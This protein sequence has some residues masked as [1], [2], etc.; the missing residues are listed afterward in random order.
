MYK[1]YCRV[2]QTILRVASYVLPWRKAS[3][4][5]GNNVFSKLSKI[6][7]EDNI[8]KVL[9]VSDRVIVDLN[10]LDEML[11]CFKK[12]KIKY[13]IYDGTV[14]NPTVKNVEEAK[15]MYINCSAQAIIA[16]G[17]GSPIDCAKAAASLIAKPNKSIKQLKGILKIRKKIPP[18]YVVPTTAG[19]GSE[20]TLA[21]VISDD[22]THQKYVMYDV[23]LIPKYAVLNPKVTINLPRSVTA[24][25]GMDV[26]THAVEAYIGRA[27]TKETLQLSKEAIVL[28]YDNLEIAC[29]DGNNLV[30]RENMLKASYLAGAAFTRAYIGYVHSLAHAIG[31]KYNLAHGWTNSVLLP[32]VLKAYGN[33]IEKPLSELA[34][35]VGVGDV[36]K[37]NKE[38]CVDFIGSIEKM[39]KNFGIPKVINQI[40]KSDLS[41]LVELAFKEANP[42]Y[43]VPK[44]LTRTDL[45]NILKE[46]S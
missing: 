35:L 18:I 43:P 2:Y 28:V 38:N 39:N 3:L 19:S 20:T 9:I 7:K 30:A 26:L 25:T 34:I 22:T 6:V 15:E 36:S 42:M 37:T 21:A 16:F 13:V 24:A 41:E 11:S 40:K 5:E 32:I 1:I 12:E 17:G 8:N 14:S 44:I 31:G 45:L 27:N 23:S 46:V 4:I 29:N 33:S 10:L